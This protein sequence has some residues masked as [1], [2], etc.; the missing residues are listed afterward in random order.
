MTRTWPGQGLPESR[1]GWNCWGEGMPWPWAVTLL[2]YQLSPLQD[3]TCVR[4]EN[5]AGGEPS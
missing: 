2:S 3:G 4:Q 5:K 1:T